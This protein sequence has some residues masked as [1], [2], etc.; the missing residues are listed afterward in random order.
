MTALHPRRVV[1]TK[2]SSPPPP[3]HWEETIWVKGGVPV[4]KGVICALE[5]EWLRDGIAASIIGV[6]CD[7]LELISFIC[8]TKEL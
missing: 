3:S 5:F 7:G 8:L 1:A 6:S 2:S 4:L